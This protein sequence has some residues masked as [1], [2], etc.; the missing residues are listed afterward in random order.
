MTP[1][2]FH[3]SILQIWRVPDPNHRFREPLVFQRIPHK[4]E[5]WVL[6]WWV[7]TCPQRFEAPFPFTYD[8]ED[9]CYLDF[10]RRWIPPGPTLMPQLF[11]H[12]ECTKSCQNEKPSWLAVFLDLVLACFQLVIVVLLFSQPFFYFRCCVTYLSTYLIIS[13]DFWWAT[14][15]G[16][17]KKNCFQCATFHRVSVCAL[18]FELCC[19]FI[20]I[21]R[22]YLVANS[23]ISGQKKFL[24]SPWQGWLRSSYSYRGF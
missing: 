11:C 12:S 21:F 22:K 6:T 10:L 7:A 8:K 17:M 20:N 1:K 19:R 4:P 2:G 24:F 5:L 16:F 9:F 15:D 23:M 13:D 3:E 14:W 18:V